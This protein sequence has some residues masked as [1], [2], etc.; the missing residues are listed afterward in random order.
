MTLNLDVVQEM[1]F[2]LEHQ[3][4]PMSLAK[5]LVFTRSVSTTV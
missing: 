4:I 3:V 1:E 2:L 5:C